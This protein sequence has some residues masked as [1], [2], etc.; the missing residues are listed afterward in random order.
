MPP[1]PSTNRSHSNAA[2]GAIAVL[3][4]LLLLG[5]ISVAIPFGSLRSTG[6]LYKGGGGGAGDQVQDEGGSGN[7]G[8]QVE[9]GE[10]PLGLAVKEL[11]RKMNELRRPVESLLNRMELLAKDSKRR[12]GAELP[13]NHQLIWKEAANQGKRMFVSLVSTNAEACQAT[14]ES[15]YTNAETPSMIY[16]GLVELR[17]P[18][19]PSCVLPSYALC[20]QSLF[21]PSDNIRVR[22]IRPDAY[23]GIP[24]L[25]AISAQLYQSE[26]FVASIQP[27]FSFAKVWDTTLHQQYKEAKKIG[28]S[29]VV[30]STKPSILEGEPVAELLCKFNFGQGP[31]MAFPELK[32]AAFPRVVAA[33]ALNT[34]PQLRQVPFASYQLFFGE[35][36]VLADIAPDPFLSYIEAPEEELVFSLRLY[37]SGYTVYS[38]AAAIGR[39]LPVATNGPRI[40]LNQTQ[41]EV[42]RVAVV[43]VALITGLIKES[44]LAAPS[45]S[46]VGLLKWKEFKGGDEKSA[47]Q[48]FH[49]AGVDLEKQKAQK[50]WCE[51]P[52][53]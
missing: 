13:K 36:E 45:L 49:F 14:L 42:Q 16:V 9:S 53:K 48:F 40:Q 51:A 39:L 37:T 10:V 22:V 38:P 17:R 12:G 25:R 33:G 18:E 43:R 41:I 5:L 8:S 50:E 7:E 27:G 21:C 52:S 31:Q 47:S 30:L 28:L 2:K 15:L 6:G 29:R 46:D 11:K 1:H 35:R 24:H 19:D 32:S 34:S 23:L 44:A 4:V 20:N 3:V 26:G